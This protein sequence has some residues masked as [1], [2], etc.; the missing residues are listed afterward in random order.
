MDLHQ[1][2][3]IPHNS[4]FL[5]QQIGNLR[6][7]SPDTLI[8][9]AVSAAIGLP[10]LTTFVPGD[11]ISTAACWVKSGDTLLLLAD[12]IASSGQGIGTWNGYVGGPLDSFRSPVN[13]WFAGGAAKML[14]MLPLS[15]LTDTRNFVFAG[16]SAGGCEAMA[17]AIAGYD[18]QLFT[19]PRLATFGSPRFGNEVQAN[20]FH[21][22]YLTRWMNDTDPVTLVPPRVGDMPILPA[23]VGINGTIRLGNFVHAPGGAVLDPSG[24]IAPG[25]IAPLAPG[26]FPLAIGAWLVGGDAA[27]GSPHH[28]GTYVTRLQLWIDAHPDNASPVRIHTPAEPTGQSARN[29]LS[30]EQAAQE[31]M[32]FVNASAQEQAPQKIPDA[33]RFKAFRIG[34]L[35][36]VSLNGNVVCIAPGKRRA[37]GFANAGNDFFARS[38]RE[39]YVDT[40]Q[41]VATMQEWLA[42]AQDPSSGIT[43]LISNTLP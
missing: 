8:R 24:N 2:L 27:A 5:A 15:Y 9:D 29:Q 17:A 14:G 22:S 41:L 19:F 6:Q 25:E 31:T 13:D 11:D 38:L 32:L 20:R 7:P 35:W 26:A 21:P 40:D 28:I 16:W 23:V 42:A 33:F 37:R 1:S 3:A 4:L 36:Y 30:R 39:G 34:R 18:R 10:A 12:G 43:P